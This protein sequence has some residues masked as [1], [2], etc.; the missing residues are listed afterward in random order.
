[1]NPLERSVEILMVIQLGLIGASHVVHHRAW[2]E[3]FVWLRAKGD[4]G[5]FLNGFLSLATGSLIVGFHRVWSGIPLVLTVFGI[6]NLLKAANCFLLPASAT[7]SMNRVAVERSHEFIVA[8]VVS[9]ALSRLVAFH[10][11]R[12][13]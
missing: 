11:L 4:S 10:L 7:R 9:L 3:F 5:A 1:M 6:L 13:A 2:A 8:G 12:A